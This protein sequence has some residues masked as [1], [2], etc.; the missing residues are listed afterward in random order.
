MVVLN[1]AQTGAPLR[2]DPALIL[3][4]HLQTNWVAVV[5]EFNPFEFNPLEFNTYEVIAK[6]LITWSRN[7]TFYSKNKHAVIIDHLRT[8]GPAQIIGAGRYRFTGEYICEIIST[9]RNLDEAKDK[10]FGIKQEI[11]R[12]IKTAI[13]ALN[14][15][16]FDEIGIDE[17]TDSSSTQDNIAG[18]MG[19]DMVNLAREKATITVIYDLIV[20]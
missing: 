8:K 15:S 6:T 17:F 5:P 4:N 14:S 1:T 13:S 11:T 10:L 20:T 9:G 7:Y 18:L 2:I 12:I 16:G 3:L 19:A